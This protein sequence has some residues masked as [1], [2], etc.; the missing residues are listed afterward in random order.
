M[1]TRAAVSLAPGCA[2][3]ARE[4][5]RRQLAWWRLEDLGDDATLIVSE[6][7]SNAVRHG[8]PPWRARMWLKGGESG[9]RGVRL[10]V[11]DAGAGV[12][13]ERIRARWRH[14]SGSLLGG[15]RGL[16]IVDTLASALGN[17]RSGHGHTV[18][19]ELES[20]RTS[21]EPDPDAA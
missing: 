5:I 8:R 16:F 12:D 4:A 15:G 17:E 6:L 11:H 3:G 20:A 9:R 21:A 1:S 13:I 18:W 19:A 10:E 2:T 7:L 14:P